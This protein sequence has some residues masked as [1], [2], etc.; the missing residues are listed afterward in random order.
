[1]ITAIT[2]VP[3]DIVKV[4]QKIQ[5]GEKTRTQIFE[6]TVLAIRGRGENKTFHVQKMVGEIA[7][8]RIWPIGSPL[9]EKVEVKAHAKKRVKRAKLYNLQKPRPVVH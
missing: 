8:E 9:I 4:Y 3:G 2:F 7:V 6:G 1:M 5:E